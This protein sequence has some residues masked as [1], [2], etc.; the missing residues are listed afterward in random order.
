MMQRKGLVVV[1]VVVVG[2]ASASKGIVVV[3]GRKGD[4]GEVGWFGI[5]GKERRGLVSGG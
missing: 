5:V 4:I 1:V 2:L 3:I